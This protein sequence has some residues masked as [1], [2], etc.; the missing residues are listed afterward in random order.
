MS[1]EDLEGIRVRQILRLQTLILSS[2]WK[3][4]KESKGITF[5]TMKQEDSEHLTLKC[6]ATFKVPINALYDHY[7][8]FDNTIDGY[9]AADIYFNHKVF[10]E[11]DGYG[12]YVIF[13]KYPFPFTNR[14]DLFSRCSEMDNKKAYVVD[15]APRKHYPREKGF[16]RTA[17]SV[18]GVL[19][20]EHPKNPKHTLVTHVLNVNIG[21]SVPAWLSN[22]WISL[23]ISSAV[24]AKDKLEKSLGAE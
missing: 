5:S 15:D 9:K 6:E 22:L 16:I 3:K 23:V 14:E 7:R 13:C 17:R 4:I 12:H 21:G 2:D 11:G 1:L 18:G 24:K 20:E 10:E 8:D 19:L